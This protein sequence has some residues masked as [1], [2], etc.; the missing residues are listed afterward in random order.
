MVSRRRFLVVLGG[1]AVAA[2]AVAVGAAVL[3]DGRHTGGP[4]SIRYGQERCAYCG[5]T[6]GDARFAAAWRTTGGAEQH[7]DD[8]GCMVNAGR[9]RTPHP[10]TAYF[11][12]DYSDESWLDAVAARYVISPAIKTP[13]AYGVAAFSEQH[14]PRIAGV[15]E[16]APLAWETLTQRVERKG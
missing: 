12:H 7:F 1:G 9:E 2:G 11:V 4:P 8:I 5:M 3:P 16:H 6:I 13:M 14:P 15:A 10:G